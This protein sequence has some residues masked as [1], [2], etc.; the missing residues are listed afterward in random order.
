MRRGYDVS[1]AGPY[2]TSPRP[3]LLR[4]EV[5]WQEPVHVFDRGLRPGHTFQVGGRRD[6]GFRPHRHSVWD[7]ED[8][9][10]ASRPLRTDPLP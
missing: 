9:I 10:A 8:I 2:L 1:G 5:P 4:A 6:R 3:S 7:S